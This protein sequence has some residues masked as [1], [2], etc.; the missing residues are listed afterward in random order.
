MPERESDSKRLGIW[1]GVGKICNWVQ[2][3]KKSQQ[4]ELLA[5]FMFY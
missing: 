5:L 2:K 1:C 4:I 3:H